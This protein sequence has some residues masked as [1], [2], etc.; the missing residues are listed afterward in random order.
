MF[1]FL[2]MTLL[3]IASFLSPQCAVA[4]NQPRNVQARNQIALKLPNANQGIS[5]DQAYGYSSAAAGNYSQA[6]DNSGY[7][8]SEQILSG[9][10][11]A[12]IPYTANTA[13][14]QIA[15]SS[16]YGAARQASNP[17]MSSGEIE[18][19]RRAVLDG[20]FFRWH[21]T[22]SSRMTRNR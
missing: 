17:M 14:N 22:Q 3:T 20:S 10:T 12:L 6:I 11:A 13:Y 8:Y 18:A 9:N 15:A 16:S 5:A 1:A 4:Q 7:D 19:A 2:F 21:G